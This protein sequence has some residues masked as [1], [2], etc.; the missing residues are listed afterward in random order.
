MVVI[1]LFLNR[2]VFSPSDCFLFTA[3][4]PIKHF[5]YRCD[6]KFHLDQLIQ[7]YEIHD[8]YAIILVSGKR[9]EYYLHNI[10]CTKFLKSIEEDL[11]NQFRK[12]GQSAQRLERIR[13]QKIGWYIKKVV[14]L[15]VQYY[16]LDGQFKYKGLVIAGPAEMKQLIQDSD[17]FTQYFSKYLLKVVTISEI[18]QNS[19]TSV[20]QMSS[21]VL[22]SQSDEQQVL[23]N[24]EKKILD[25]NQLDLLVFGEEQVLA[26]FY[27]GHLKDIYL[28]EQNI[29]KDALINDNQKT[30]IIIIKSNIFV[31]KYG[32]IVGVKYYMHTEFDENDII[33]NDIIEV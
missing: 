26:D 1:I 20:I 10:N 22:S 14:E 18:D 13:D 3:P 30:N 9:V 25:P 6:K 28:F 4:N 12:G 19:I 23:I 8:D 15:M 16:V 21:D 11:P 29:H 31:S 32:Q 2:A 17:L 24:F 5:F 33:Q 27:L 7:L